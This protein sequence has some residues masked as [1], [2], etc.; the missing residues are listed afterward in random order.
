MQENTLIG[1]YRITSPLGK[2]GMGEVY[3][4][5]DTDL[6]RR[7]ALK[8]LPESVR[9]DPDR[10]ARF[11]REA[12][13]AAQLNHPNIA[14][15]YS[16]EEADGPEGTSIL[17][18]VME[19]VDGVSLKDVIPTDGMDVGG[20]NGTGRGVLKY[21]PTLSFYDVFIPLS[22][23]LAHAH[24]NHITH[25]DLKPGNIMIREDGVPKILDFGLA[26]I[27]S[28]SQPPAEVDTQAPTRT[29]DE[30]EKL[31]PIEPLTDKPQFMGTPQYMSPEQAS[32]KE[33][34][35]RTDLFSFGI[36]MYEALAGQRPFQGNS[37]PEIVSSILKDAPVPVREVKPDLPY[38]VDQIVMR[39][40]RKPTVDR[41]QSAR[42]LHHDLE[43]VAEEN[44]EAVYV[45]A[46]S[47]TMLTPFQR[48]VV[49]LSGIVLSLI[50]G[51]VIAWTLKPIPVSETPLRK[52][53]LNI[54]T[55]AGLY[56]GG[57]I[58]PD[59]SMLAYEFPAAIIS[60]VYSCPM[61]STS[62]GIIWL[63]C[64]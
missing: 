59:G 49:I 28:P 13:A 58:S 55:V 16:I 12:T 42:D 48:P 37:Q 61:I 43:G 7:V 18:I 62:S 35:H 17:L 41:Y 32:L 54:D 19:Y 25:R 23:G 34:D 44:R 21:V 52:F 50:I 22:D 51:L 29:M 8:V 47:S 11:R 63:P 1:H 46:T 4:A 15:I 45:S 38:R 57:V 24:E 36:I 53:T 6:K 10:L 2:G 60:R 40:L 39:C 31:A 27:T 56:D 33:L 14:Q 20:S 3:L 5:E 64:A 9:D 26:R 30:D